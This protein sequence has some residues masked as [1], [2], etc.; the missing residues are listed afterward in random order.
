MYAPD[1]RHPRRQS[2]PSR[3]L[4]VVGRGDMTSVRRWDA[5]SPT[6]ASLAA[7]TTIGYNADGSVIFRRDPSGHKATLAYYD[8][9]WS[10]TNAP[11]EINRE[12]YTSRVLDG[13]GRVRATASSLPS[14][15]GAT[16]GSS[17][18]T[19]PRAG[20]RGSRTRRRRQ[21][22][23]LGPPPTKTPS[24]GGSTRRRSTTGRAGR[25]WPP[26]RSSTR[27]TRAKRP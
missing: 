7:E 11:G 16:R 13:V 8:K 3:R 20:S 19:T 6:N 15:N 21:P 26:R 4:F 25:C 2:A 24:T 9:F 22:R 17:S 1:C 27:T 10:P 14:S 5:P 12:S 18:T 23:A